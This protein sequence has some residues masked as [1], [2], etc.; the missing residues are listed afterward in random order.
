[1]TIKHDG[2]DHA[3]NYPELGGVEDQK[4][5]YPEFAIFNHP[6]GSIYQ[7]IRGDWVLIQRSDGTKVRDLVS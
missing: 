6:S 2:S 3:V 5:F 7:Q 4:V 1:M